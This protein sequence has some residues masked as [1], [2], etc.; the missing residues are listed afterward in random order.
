MIGFHIA[1]NNT[2]IEY[3][4]AWNKGYIDENTCEYEVKGMGKTFTV[5]HK[6]ARGWKKLLQIILE[7]LP[8]DRYSDD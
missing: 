6:R 5:R 1:V 8:E 4:T 2:T 7:E 3:I